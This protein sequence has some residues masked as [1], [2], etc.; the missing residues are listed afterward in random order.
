MLSLTSPAHAQ[1]G[2]ADATAGAEA[3][4]GAEAH[5]AF[6]PF[7]PTTF[8]SQLVWL[9]IT[10][11][12]LL[13]LM[14]R[15]AAPRI[16]GIL[17]E[18]SRKIAGDLAE[19][20]RLKDATDAAIAAHERALAEARQNAHAIGQRSR[21]KVKAEIE[22]ERKRIEGGL[23]KR[24]DAAEARIDEVKRSALT[25]VDTIAR[26]ATAAIIETLVEGGAG[27]AEIRGA[28]ERAMAERS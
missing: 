11:G 5:G 18:R 19:A 7:D 21:D 16:G 8:A 1:G 24:L 9:A 26:D 13:L 2:H 22:A 25:Q 23:Q 14:S 15:V 28:V 6:P 10:F 17:E 20:G 12:I 4:A 27:E 3:S